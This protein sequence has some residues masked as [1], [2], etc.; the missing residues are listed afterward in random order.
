[1]QG[2]QVEDKAPAEFAALA[3]GEM[4]SVLLF[5]SGPDLL[6]LAMAPETFDANLDQDVVADGA[7]RRNQFRQALSA[8]SHQRAFSFT[9]IPRT[10]TPSDSLTAER[11]TMA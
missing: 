2:F 4:D 7:F 11:G 10:R 6:A 8:P 1:M 9:T 3:A 5:Q